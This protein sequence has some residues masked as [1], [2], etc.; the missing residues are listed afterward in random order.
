MHTLNTH[1]LKLTEP[2]IARRQQQALQT[3]EVQ[4]HMEEQRQ[5]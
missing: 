3:D 2:F 1:L 5:R 4:E